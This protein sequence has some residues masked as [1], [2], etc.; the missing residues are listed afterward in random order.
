MMILLI[1]FEAESHRQQQRI[2][3]FSLRYSVWDLIQTKRKTEVTFKIRT[4]I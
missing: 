2:E 3:T 1:P 4:I